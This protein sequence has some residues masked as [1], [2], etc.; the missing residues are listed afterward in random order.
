[1]TTELT[2][3]VHALIHSINPL[4]Y[5]RNIAQEMLQ[6]V[7]NG[8]E[9][10]P[11]GDWPEFDGN[12]NSHILGRETVCSMLNLEYNEDVRAPSMQ[13]ARAILFSV[14]VLLELIVKH[15]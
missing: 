8:T 2:A 10:I 9:M 5:C 12:S 15:Q 4:M 6:A 11:A 13:V 14:S 1:M 3:G 7:S